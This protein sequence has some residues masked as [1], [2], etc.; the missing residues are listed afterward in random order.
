MPRFEGKSLGRNRF[1][2]PTKDR[3]KDKNPLIDYLNINSLRNKITDLRGI[4]KISYLHYL[5]LRET[6]LDESFSSA[7][8]TAE[9]YEIRATCDREKYGGS[10]GI[11]AKRAYMY[12]IKGMRD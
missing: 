7:Q 2:T 12:M 6:K 5:V 8:L 1:S 10:N 9:G 4:M 11:C 3:L